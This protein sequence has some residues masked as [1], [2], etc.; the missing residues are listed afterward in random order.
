MFLIGR[1]TETAASDNWFLNELWVNIIAALSILLRTLRLYHD[2]SRRSLPVS[3]MC[4]EDR[5][6][7]ANTDDTNPYTLSLRSV[8]RLYPDT[9]SPGEKMVLGTCRIVKAGGGGANNGSIERI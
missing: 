9:G 6:Q 8:H 2:D 1:G 5:G 4:I 3:Q 7:V